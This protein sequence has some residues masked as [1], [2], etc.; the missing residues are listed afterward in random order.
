M[1]AD[2]QG[3]GDELWDEFVREF[4]KS[5]GIHEPSAAERT[6]VAQSAGR[7]WRR[8]LLIGAAGAGTLAVLAGVGL[9]S[10]SPRHSAAAG[11]ADSSP[12]PGGSTPVQAAARTPSAGG[13]AEAV[14]AAQAFPARVGGYTRVASVTDKVC[15]GTDTV[16]PT[17]AGLITQSRGCRGVAIALYRDAAGDEFDLDVFSMNDPQDAAH[18][19]FALGAN[20]TDDEVVVQVPPANSGLRALPADSGLVQAFAGTK[21]LAVVGLAQ[22]SDGRSRDFQALTDKLSPLLDAVTKEAGGH[23][24]A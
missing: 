22:W 4:H 9:F 15:T 11:T 24:G 13:S 16:G 21:R 1:T 10:S 6:P 23:A 2:D 8:W 5:K 19:V 7:S 18:L 12:R 20:P 14:T 17:L 3:T